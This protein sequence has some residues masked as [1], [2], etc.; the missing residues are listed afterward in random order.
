MFWIATIAIIA[1][2][3]FLL[4]QSRM[5][6]MQSE[7]RAAYME[8]GLSY[9]E[10]NK[11]AWYLIDMFIYIRKKKDHNLARMVVKSTMT[12]F[13]QRFYNNQAY[14]GNI[15]ARMQME[16]IKDACLIFNR[17]AVEAAD[18]MYSSVVASYETYS[19]RKNAYWPNHSI[20]RTGHAPRR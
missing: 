5:W 1:V 8:E 7:I 10:A 15:S 13:R 11:V 4:D 19:K 20:K 3:L 2:G 16:G 18:L 12:V 6:R 9:D 14:A 17:P